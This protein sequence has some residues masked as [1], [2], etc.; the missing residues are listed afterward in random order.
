M[1]P[2]KRVRRKIVR[3]KPPIVKKQKTIPPPSDK[4]RKYKIALGA[5]S[6]AAAILIS[7]L[8]AQ[9]YQRSRNHKSPSPP[10]SPASSHGSSNMLRNAAAR[11]ENRR[12]SPPSSRGSSNM[13]RNAV[14]RM[15]SHGSS[16]NGWNNLNFSRG[17]PKKS[18]WKVKKFFKKCTKCVR[19]PSNENTL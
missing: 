17:P 15:E 7:G 12:Y 4:S 2:I 19:R 1:P 8:L 14:A 11:M 6:I 16:G 5:S 3:R 18:G 13:L 10:P 9:K